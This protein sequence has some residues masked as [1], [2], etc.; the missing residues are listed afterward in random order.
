MESM[1]REWRYGPRLKLGEIPQEELLKKTN[2]KRSE[3]NKENQERRVIE[4]KGTDKYK[5][6]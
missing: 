6:P 3:K 2:E 1:Q 5:E 4:A